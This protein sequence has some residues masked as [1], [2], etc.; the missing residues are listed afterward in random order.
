[1]LVDEAV[2]SWPRADGCYGRH[3]RA[4][5]A[6]SADLETGQG[7]PARIRQGSTL[8]I[9]TGNALAAE[10]GRFVVVQRSFADLGEE[11]AARVLVGRPTACC[12]S[13]SACP[14]R[15]WTMPSVAFSFLNDGP[16]D[17]RMNRM[18][19]SVPPSSSPAPA[20]TRLPAFQGI[21]R[22]ASPRMARVPWSS[23]ANS[24][25]SSAPPTWHRC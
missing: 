13:T 23:A 25:H 14:R 6:Q 10:T 7:S 16:L 1:M 2:G 15:S 12:C 22:G 9:A 17:M 18:P 24:N 20:P 19:A 8:A 11:L 4:W 3:L 21:R 5:G